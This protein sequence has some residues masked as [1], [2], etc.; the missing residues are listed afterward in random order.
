MRKSLFLGVLG[1]LLI[2][3]L[4]FPFLKSDAAFAPDQKNTFRAKPV[5]P[6]G[7]LPDYDIR[8]EGK[9]E[10]TDTE[11]SG[12]TAAQKTGINSAIAARA[13]AVD[14][15]RSNLKPGDAEN[16]RATV[17]ETG[18]M[19]AFFIDGAALSAPQSDTA[20]NIARGFLK[21]HASVFS[22]SGADVE[23][24]SVSVEDN[25]R[26]T[27]FLKY[28]QTVGGIKVFEGGV[29][30]VVNKNGEVIN[31]REGFLVSG[32]SV[33]LKP[34]L[35]EAKAMARAFE[36]AGHKVDESFVETQTRASKGERSA[37]ANP[38]STAN[39]EV[40]S[41]LN[42]VRIGDTAKLAWHVFAETGKD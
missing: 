7:P 35:S 22:L 20:D 29:D 17:N 41:E 39:E 34:A 11:L 15:F 25:D 26:G 24:L 5:L 4:V 30:V 33:K 28:I 40:L 8:L 19:K 12:S 6:P 1:T 13:S 27:T 10:F 38:L 42:V 32:Q 3:A 31:V 16:L 2:S 18:A 36:Y 9:G 37:F 23:N 21:Q 14:Q